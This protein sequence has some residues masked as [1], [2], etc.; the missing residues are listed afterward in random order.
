MNGRGVPR[1]P[2]KAIAWFRQAAL[3][4]HGPAMYYLGLMQLRGWGLPQDREKARNWLTKAAAAGSEAAER[5]LEE[6]E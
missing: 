5:A 3:Q 6:L 1:I 2:D 4:D